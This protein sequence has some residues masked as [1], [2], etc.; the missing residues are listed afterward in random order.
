FGRGPLGSVFRGVLSS[1]PVVVKFFRTDDVVAD[2]G[3]LQKL[4]KELNLLYE[5]N[6]PNL[7]K[8]LGACHVSLPPFIVY[9]DIPSG[10]LSSFLA[11]SEDNKRQMWGKLHQAAIGLDYIHK[12]GLVHGDL[13]LSNILVSRSGQ[14]KLMDFGL[15]VL[16]A[17]YSSSQT[18]LRWSSPEC[19]K[20]RPTFASDVY[21]LAMCIVEA[22]TG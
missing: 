21:S 18:T 9:E 3:M 1:T 17:F 10:N 19:L 12:K 20:R 11:R 4:G 8:I 16:R 14:V 5:I 7:V 2:V 22:V 13:K 6:H 15:N